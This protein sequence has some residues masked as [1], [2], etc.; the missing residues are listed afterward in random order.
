MSDA[1][2][3]PPGGSYV[4]PP[5]AHLTGSKWWKPLATKWGIVGILI[6]ASLLFGV[7]DA[8]FFETGD[9]TKFWPG[10]KDDA[11]ISRD[12]VVGLA[13]LPGDGSP[14]LFDKARALLHDF[15]L[16]RER[17]DKAARKS[18]QSE[19]ARKKAEQQRSANYQRMSDAFRELERGLLFKHNQQLVALIQESINLQDFHT[20]YS[21]ADR[22]ID[23]AK[24]QR[25]S[26]EELP[27]LERELS[28]HWVKVK[29]EPKWGL[30]FGDI[31]RSIKE[32]ELHLERSP[33]SAG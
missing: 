32:Y 13:E 25:H 29:S 9:D 24:K 28:D 6:F 26:I 31:E 23:R 2:L 33:A 5:S 1:D 30:V 21:F 14:K 7:I 10:K 8:V 27:R 16:L 17:A 19:L 3:R 4:P 20:A 18:D 12:L 11:S 22:Y 15:Y